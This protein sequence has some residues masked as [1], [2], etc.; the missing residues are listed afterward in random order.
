MATTTRNAREKIRTARAARAKLQ[1]DKAAER[2]LPVADPDEA[3]VDAVLTSLEALLD[4]ADL[5]E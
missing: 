4:E 3:F 1:Q 2:V 5:H